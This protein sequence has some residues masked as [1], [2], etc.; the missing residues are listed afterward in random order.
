M[1]APPKPWELARSQST[2][3]TNPETSTA[4]T[5]GL[6]NPPSSVLSTNSL[7]NPYRRSLYNSPFSGRSG[8]M[9]YGMG[10]MGLGYGMGGM[11]GM[12]Y[13]MGGMGYGMQ[14]YGTP[15]KGMI[16]IERFSMLVN[17]LCFTAETIE[18]SMNS[19]KIFW[20]TII[21]IKA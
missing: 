7:T 11:G 4:T 3:L 18:N 19:M 6:G 21:R 13:G 8:M 12:G 16:A 14:Q 17:S 9:G 15:S 2:V 20:E 10:G 5:S 1:T